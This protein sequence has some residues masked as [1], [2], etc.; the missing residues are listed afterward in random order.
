[1][2][3]SILSDYVE[4][5]PGSPGLVCI[6][7]IKT[8]YTIKLLEQLNNISEIEVRDWFDYFILTT[9]K[10]TSEVTKLLS[11]K[12]ILKE[13]YGDFLIFPQHNMRKWLVR[14]RIQLE[15]HPIPKIVCSEGLI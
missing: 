8:S 6:E 7:N 3:L 4:E 11:E 1:M 12:P 9:L 5:N 13:R 10:V 2:T 14:R 15:E